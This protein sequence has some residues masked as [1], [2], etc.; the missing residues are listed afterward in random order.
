[1]YIIKGSDAV[2]IILLEKKRITS[3]DGQ[4]TAL[5][6]EILKRPVKIEDVQGYLEGLR[7]RAKLEVRL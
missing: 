6:K 3:L 7:S 5:E 2:R 1:M 4:R